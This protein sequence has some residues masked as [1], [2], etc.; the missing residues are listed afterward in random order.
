MPAL[1]GSAVKRDATYQLAGLACEGRD[2]HPLPA[3]LELGDDVLD[4]RRLAYRCKHSCISAAF[5]LLSSQ[6]RLLSQ[7]LR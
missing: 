3:L 5:V 4:E 2:Q 6:C 1:T 7:H